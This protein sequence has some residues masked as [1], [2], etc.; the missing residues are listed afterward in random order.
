LTAE[1]VKTK[2]DESVFIVTLDNPPVN[3]LNLKMLDELSAAVKQGNEDPEVRGIVISGS[4]NNAF[5]AGADLKMMKS[6]EPEEAVNIISTG[7]RTF[8]AI[9]ESSKPVIA[10][11]NGLALGGGNELAMS[12]DLRFVSDRARF[13]QPEVTLGLIP[14][15]GGTQRLTRMVG[16]GKSK[17]LI[18]SGQIINAQEAL[19]IGLVNKI[20]PDGEELR[21]A[22]DYIRM[23]SAKVSPLALAQAKIA[24]DK[25]SQKASL[26]EGLEYEVEAIRVLAQ[27][28]DLRE[29]VQAFLEKRPPKFTG[30]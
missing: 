8:M 1:F 25:G 18:F 27:S 20:V 2:K 3:A 14:A 30:K 22:S 24:I 5:C 7:H 11:V 29:G 13:G 12:C 26:E 19:R 21:A 16:K 17:E 4:G 6:L 28:Q 9:E 10:A 15:W 23:L